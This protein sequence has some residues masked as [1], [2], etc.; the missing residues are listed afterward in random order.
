MKTLKKISLSELQIHPLVIGI[1][2]N[3][4]NPSIQFSMKHDGQKTPIVVVKRDV[5][6]LIVDGVL[7]YN[8]AVELGNIE[9]LECRILDIADGQV[10]DAR[11][12]YNQKS[13]VHTLEICRNI[14]HI[15]GLIGNEQGKRND[16]LSNKNFDKEDEFGTTSR[17]RYEK[18]CAY[19]GLP[20]STRTLY[21]LMKVHDFEKTDNSLG[22]IDGINSGKFKIDGAH[23]LMKSISD[24]QSKKARRKQI[25]IDRVTSNVWFELFEQS[26]TDLSNLKHLKPKF[27]MFS[28]P[29]WKM[30]HYRNQGEIKYG[31]EPTLQQ[32]LDNSRKIMSEL[33]NILDENAVVVIVI[34]EAYKGGYKSIT[35][36]YELM[37][38]DCGLDILGVCEW[39]KLNP[40]PAVP[41]YFFRPANEKIFVCKKN[42]AEISF[43]PKMRPT[44][45][46][47]S[48]V[49]KCHSA[50]NGTERFFVED[51]STIISNVITTAAFNHNEYKKYD[52]NFNHDAPC[53]MEIYDIMVSSYTMPGDTCIDIHCGSGQG[54]EV[55]ARNGCNAIGVDIDPV[56]VEFCN[57]RMNMVLGERNQDLEFK[58]AA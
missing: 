42:C 6:Y 26:A 27:A 50:N 51:D 40:T 44:K 15:L 39:V 23:K 20:F 55:F 16:L 4:S 29:Y 3:T 8:A 12:V 25:E 58:Q 45:D 47:K 36:R 34:G 19:S 31:Q 11:I 28:P 57:K 46:G 13:K 18:A 7:R 17:Y 5:G 37:L 10:L 41:K 35:S 48:S 49:K 33:V 43:N 22:L 1:I 53:P 9:T 52:P 24:K 21:K 56:S 2:N 38:L 32:Y 30:R 54:L 14:E